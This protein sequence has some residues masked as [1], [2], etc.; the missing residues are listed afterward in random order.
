MTA[1][2]RF[3]EEGEEEEGPGRARQMLAP[4]KVPMEVFRQIEDVFEMTVGRDW[5]EP[6]KMRPSIAAYICLRKCR[7][8][9]RQCIDSMLIY[10]SSHR[11]RPE[12]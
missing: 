5:C 3:V 1:I 6:S 8:W 12:D 2:V 11:D 7:V 4:A 9:V 10:P